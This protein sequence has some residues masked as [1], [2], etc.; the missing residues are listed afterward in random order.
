MKDRT[1]VTRRTVVG[2]IG[3]GTATALLGMPYIARAQ[4]DTIRTGKPMRIVS[5]W[6][7][8]M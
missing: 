3:V 4:S 8:A 2:G 7:R 6:A 1:T 5:L